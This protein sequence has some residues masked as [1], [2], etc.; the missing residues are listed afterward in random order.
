VTRLDTLVTTA[1]KTL[2]PKPPDA[3]KREVKKNYSEAISDV[4]AVAFAEE[5]RQRG[6]K[7]HCRR[8]LGSQVPPAPSGEWLEG[9][10]RKAS[11]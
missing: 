7:A 1:L 2:G 5:L 10:V 3:A 6:L 11:T 9:L 8:A 4:I